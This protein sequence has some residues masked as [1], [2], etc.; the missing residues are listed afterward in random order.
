MTINCIWNIIILAFD[1]ISSYTVISLLFNFN[2]VF[3]SESKKTK[4]TPIPYRNL[5][6]SRETPKNPPNSR[7]TLQHPTR[8]PRPPS[9]STRTSVWTIPTQTTT[10]ATG[11]LAP[12]TPKTPTNNTNTCNNQTQQLLHLHPVN[13]NNSPKHKTTTTILTLSFCPITDRSRPALFR[14]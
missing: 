11:T 9:T 5:Q 4:Q 7:P 1:N 13:N 8:A 10:Q 6:N 12:S 3:F 14:A 2:N